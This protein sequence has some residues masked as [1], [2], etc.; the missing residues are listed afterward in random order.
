[1]WA[2]P[3]LTEAPR[4]SSCNPAV[5]SSNV[6]AAG[7]LAAGMPPVF[8]ALAQPE[9]PE[10]TGIDGWIRLLRLVALRGKLVDKT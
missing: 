9:A 8:G 5:R 2:P 4:R 6:L 1:M 10:F 7:A 3:D